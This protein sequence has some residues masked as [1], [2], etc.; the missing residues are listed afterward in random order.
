MRVFGAGQHGRHHFFT[1]GGRATCF[2]S[3]GGPRGAIDAFLSLSGGQI[4]RLRCRSNLVGTSAPI[5][6]ARCVFPGFL[7]LGLYLAF[8][9]PRIILFSRGAHPAPPLVEQVDFVRAPGVSGARPSIAPGGPVRP[10]HPAGPFLGFPARAGA[11]FSLR[12]LLPRPQSGGGDRTGPAFSFA[13]DAAPPQTPVARRSEPAGAAA[14]DGRTRCRGE[15]YPAFARK[16][17]GIGG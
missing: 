16:L 1:D 11:A 13:H 4:D 14:R 7:R 17:W 10:H 12:S 15:T 8:V 2:R 6:R 9:V 3:C 5:P